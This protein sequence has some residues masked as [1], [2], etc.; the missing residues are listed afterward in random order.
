MCVLALTEKNINDH[1]VHTTRLTPLYYNI[2]NTQVH[3]L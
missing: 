1:T 3:K 2:P